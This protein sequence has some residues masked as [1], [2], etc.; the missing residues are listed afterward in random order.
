MREMISQD[1]RMVCS[2]HFYLFYLFFY[3]RVGAVGLLLLTALLR[4]LISPQY[5]PDY[6]TRS[7]QGGEGRREGNLWETST[8]T[9][10]YRWY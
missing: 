9:V 7:S 6:H 3:V 2:H 10:R 8:S 1:D 4:W 5:L